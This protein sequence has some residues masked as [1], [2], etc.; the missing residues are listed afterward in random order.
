[1]Q[2]QVFPQG[3]PGGHRRLLG[4]SRGDPIVGRDA[5]PA[6][7]R[8]RAA[9]GRHAPPVGRERPSAAD[10]RSRPRASSAPTRSSASSTLEQ[11]MN[12]A[13]GA[14]RSGDRRAGHRAAEAGSAR[15]RP[16]RAARPKA[17]PSG[18]RRGYSRDATPG[19]RSRRGRLHAKASSCGRP[20]RYDE[21]ITSLR[22]FTA[23]YPQAPPRQLR[24]QPH[25]P[26]AAR[27][28]RRARRGRGAPR[29]LSQ[30]PE[31]RARARQPVSISARR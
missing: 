16:R 31:R 28:G 19:H 24:Q 22:A 4:R 12:E 27:Q 10:A 14:P 17:G 5:R 9:D 7:R 29:Q 6:A 2:R 25:R 11:R 18:G 23:A 21:A 8:A 20:A 15:S 30:Q 26:R 13:A 3:P 1:M